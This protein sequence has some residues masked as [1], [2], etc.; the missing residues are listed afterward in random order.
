MAKTD[1]PQK[2]VEYK[3]KN[4][5]TMYWFFD[6]INIPCKK[7]SRLWERTAAV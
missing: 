1:L 7:V 3:F 6:K 5:K 2:T 4:N